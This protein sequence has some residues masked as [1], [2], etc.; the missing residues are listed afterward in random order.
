M[1]E[2]Y[3]FQPSRLLISLVY[4]VETAAQTGLGGILKK[5][6]KTISKQ[7]FITSHNGFNFFFLVKSKEIVGV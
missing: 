2:S 6:K 7:H 5:I 3:L 1:N 4:L